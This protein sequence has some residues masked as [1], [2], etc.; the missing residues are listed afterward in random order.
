MGAKKDM[1]DVLAAA[2]KQGWRVRATNSGHYQL[3]APNGR[4]IVT[5]AG[6]PGSA[7]SVQKTVSR[8]RQH[9][10]VWKGH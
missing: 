6:T 8:M 2:E 1:Q 3:F 9:G 4:G 10:F 7:R 5:A